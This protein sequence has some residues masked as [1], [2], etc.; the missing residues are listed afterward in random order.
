MIDLPQLS[1]WQQRVNLALR[2]CLPAEHIIPQKLHQAMRYAVLNGG[3]RIRPV[4]AY[5]TGQALDIPVATL[6]PIACAVELVH[7]YSLVHDDLPAMDDDDLRRGMPTCHKKFDEAT[8][9]L[10]GDALQA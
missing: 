5:A 4:L 7:A 6:D 3:K 2:Q 9:I 10:C 8:A 1:A